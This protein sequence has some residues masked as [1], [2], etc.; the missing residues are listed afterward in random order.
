M[1]EGQLAD[2][3]IPSVAAQRYMP[4]QRRLLTE[5]DGQRSISEDDRTR[6][7]AELDA[8]EEQAASSDVVARGVPSVWAH[9]ETLRALRQGGYIEEDWRLDPAAATTD[10]PPDHNR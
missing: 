2:T 5:R 10:R 1:A 4:E 7:L 9:L 3:L 6:L 8:L